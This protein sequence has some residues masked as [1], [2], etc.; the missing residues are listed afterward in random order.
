MWPPRLV[1]TAY[2]ALTPA[3]S[4]AAS[5]LLNLEESVPLCPEFYGKRVGEAKGDKLGQPGRI[6]MRQIAALMPKAG[7]PGRPQPVG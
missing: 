7:T 5:I 2:R 1:V 6:P 4:E 3:L